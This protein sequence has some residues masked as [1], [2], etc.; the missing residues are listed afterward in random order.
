[1]HPCG[2]NPG[3]RPPPA[4]PGRARPAP[5]A[6]PWGRTHLERQHLP[7]SPGSG[8]RTAGPLWP[9]FLASSPAPSP[10][11]RRQRIPLCRCPAASG[12][13]GRVSK[14]TARDLPKERGLSPEAAAAALL[15]GRGGLFPGPLALCRRSSHPLRPRARGSARFPTRRLRAPGRGRGWAPVPLLPRGAARSECA[16]AGAGG[17][18][19]WQLHVAGAG[20]RCPWQGQAAGARGSCTWQVH[21]AG[22]GGGCRRPVQ[23]QRAPGAGAGDPGALQTARGALARRRWPGGLSL[24]SRNSTLQGGRS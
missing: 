17:R 13:Q 14:V 1:M 19:T 15:T 22:A 10:W 12:A 8:R 16:A 18:C 21:V 9:R 7:G 24:G 5:A 20:S 2:S 6:R 4:G 11:A 23:P 3:L